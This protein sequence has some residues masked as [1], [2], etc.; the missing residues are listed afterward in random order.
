[1]GT[2]FQVVNVAYRAEAG[3]LDCEIAGVIKAW[4]ERGAELSDDAF[5][6]LAFRIFAHQLRYNE[7]YARYAGARGFT[8]ERLPRSWREI[9]GVPAA[10]YK[11]ARLATFSTPPALA[12]ETSGTTSGQGG[13]HEMETATLY[14]AAL[15]AGFDRFVL[16]DGARLRYLLLVPDPRER[17]QSS[18]GYMMARVA[19]E[20]GAGETGW[21]VRG[22]ALLVE[23]FFRD[24]G[25]CVAAGDA[26]CIATTAFSLV[27]VL[28]AAEERGLRFPLPRGSRIMETGGFKGRT[29]VILRAELYARMC[30]CFG[31]ESSQIVSEYGM[32]E[33]TSQ[34]YAV[35]RGASSDAPLTRLAQDDRG[36]FCGPAWLRARAVAAD[37]TTLADG[38]V[39]ALCHVD[40]ANRSSCVA[41]QTEDLG[42]CFGREIVLL[43]RESGAELRGC[44]LDAETLAR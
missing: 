1:M 6:A 33:L 28:D 3:E 20:R 12:F 44:S 11:E 19:R 34:W 27:A 7:P 30:A 25:T 38:I 42:A 10:A 24:L 26:V 16:G 35:L 41:V 4:R 9:P 31:I 14:D 8:P 22:D 29:R 40:L 15:L 13:R 21:Y 5:D 32:T 43:G 17:P 36:V 2:H 23:D 37:G 18:L 39:G